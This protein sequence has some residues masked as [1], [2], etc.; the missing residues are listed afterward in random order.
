[1]YSIL[2][3]LGVL[4]LIYT[5]RVITLFY[6]HVYDVQKYNLSS[7]FVNRIIIPPRFI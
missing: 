5:C 2:I 4:I 7:G 1:M 6:N 3:A